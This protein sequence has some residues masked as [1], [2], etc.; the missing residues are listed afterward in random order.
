MKKQLNRISIFLVFFLSSAVNI[1]A[2]QRQRVDP[3]SRKVAFLGFV[4]SQ[5]IQFRIPGSYKELTNYDRFECGD[6]KYMGSAPLYPLTNEDT[7]VVIGFAIY[8]P[9]SNEKTYSNEETKRIQKIFPNFNPD[10]SNSNYTIVTRKLADTTK[11]P[12]TSFDR[13]YLEKFNAD[14]GCQ[15]SRNCNLP[16]LNKFFENRII[17]LDKKG[18][19]QLAIIYLFDKSKEQVMNKE[20]KKTMKEMIY[21]N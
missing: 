12:L 18:R 5:N 13:K 2:Q 10:N 11:L 20:I 6:R 1:A 14:N 8:Y 16:F 9:G 4:E 7:S 15:F 17:F 19:G 21:Y 3:A